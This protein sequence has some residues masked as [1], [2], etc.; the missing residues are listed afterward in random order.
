MQKTSRF[1]A[2]IYAAIIGLII[3]AIFLGFLASMTNPISWLLI[4]SL[5]L[6]PFVYNKTKKTKELKWKP[7]Y[8]VGVEVLDLD[9]QKLLTLLNQF[10]TAYDYAMSEE[11]ER[12]ALKELLDY[13]IYHFDREEKM[14]AECN[15]PDLEPHKKQHQTMINEI[16]KVEAKYNK[17]GHEALDEVSDFL[18][19]W[20]INHINHTDKDYTQH[21]NNNGI[22]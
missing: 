15:Y 12:Q 8:T 21:M 5:F 7:E 3:V 22:K 4:A 20:L 19:N 10:N 9:H 11:F 1:V 17:E 2:L 6:I 16:R 14:M 13:T 18:T